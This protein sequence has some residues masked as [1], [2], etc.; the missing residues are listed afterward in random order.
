MINSDSIR[1]NLSNEDCHFTTEP[2]YMAGYAESSE[3]EELKAAIK[4]IEEAYSWS[5]M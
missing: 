2:Y 5:E 3:V 1:I 4:E